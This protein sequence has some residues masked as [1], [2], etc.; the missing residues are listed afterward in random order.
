MGHLGRVPSLSSFTACYESARQP[1]SWGGARHG[2]PICA[3]RARRPTGTT[4][5]KITP[6]R[7][8]RRSHR[9]VSLPLQSGILCNTSHA[10]RRLWCCSPWVERWPTETGDMLMAGQW[11]RPAWGRSP[12]S[13]TL[14]HSKT[15]ACRG[16]DV[17]TTSLRGH[18]RGAIRPGV[19]LRHPAVPGS[20]AE[21][22][23]RSNR[24]LVEKRSGNALDL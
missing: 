16:N 20:A 14:A 21:K 7:P 22:T 18:G 23:P 12:S 8:S 17:V 3:G 4:R 19:H 6:R 5:R 9:S 10:G 13:T 15:C 11:R 24:N 1:S 2:L